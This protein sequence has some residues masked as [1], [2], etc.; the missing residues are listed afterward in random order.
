[1]SGFEGFSSRRRYWI[2]YFLFE[3]ILLLLALFD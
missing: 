2:E 3:I 1:M